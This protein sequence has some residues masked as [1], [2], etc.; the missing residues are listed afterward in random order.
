M[1]CEIVSN[2]KDNFLSQYKYLD[3]SHLSNTDETAEKLRYTPI[4]KIF[5]DIDFTEYEPTWQRYVGS[6]AMLDDSNDKIILAEPGSGKTTFL[7]Y[8]LS[9]KIE[10]NIIPVYWEWNELYPKIEKKID[11]STILSDHF[12]KHLSGD[13]EIA[14][15][16]AFINRNKFVFLIERFTGDVSEDCFS[17]IETFFE[18]FKESESKIFQDSYFV[19]TCGIANYPGKYFALFSR[20]GFKHYKIN[21]L[22]EDLIYRYIRKFIHHVSQ[23]RLKNRDKA[24]LV[25]N[26]IE[27][28]SIIKRLAEI[29]LFLY[30]IVV[31]YHCDGDLPPTRVELY[32]KFVEMLLY[33]WKGT[34]ED[35]KIFDEYYLDD[36]FLLVLFVETAYEYYDKFLRKEVSEFGT[37]AQAELEATISKFYACLIRRA[38][39][40]SEIKCA[41]SRLFSY[42]K[43]NRGVIVEKSNGKFGFSHL[44][45]FEYLAAKR[46]IQKYPNFEESIDYILG[47]LKEPNF[48]QIE[49]TIIFQ[50][51]LLGTKFMD[52]LAKRLLTQN[53]EHI[54]KN[55]LILLAKLLK[56]IDDL[57]R[58]NTVGILSQ[59]TVYT[60]NYPEDREISGLINDI[61]RF[62]K[63]LRDEFVYL[64]NKL[65]GE[66]EKWRDFSEKAA[67]S[68]DINVLE[69][70]KELDFLARESIGPDGQI[71]VV[72]FNGKL[73]EIKEKLR[74]LKAISTG[75]K[76]LSSDSSGIL[77]VSKGR[78]P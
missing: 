68:I 54:D 20:L 48:S 44:T 30:L 33:E 3:L 67:N 2:Y 14:A 34:Y 63:R 73:R 32:E 40:P 45:L 39:N 72:E 46:P 61:F 76:R 58:D 19:L 62:S 12:K 74:L 64:L 29:P 1:N 13:F 11:F 56:D 16:D 28:R 66:K 47:A 23:G 31:I 52:L 41:V 35:V 38:M 26:Y 17:S 65:Q 51:E 69:M 8:I 10:E 27:T 70:E 15:V 4:D 77:R 55:A 36:R 71:P 5:V 25:M 21:P 53:E 75:Y 49:G 42:F 50:I 22:N 59:L 57:S 60:F 18:D 9:R 24:K 7:K 37:F 78:N 6:S 43:K